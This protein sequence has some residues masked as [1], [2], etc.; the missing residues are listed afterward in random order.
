M[1]ILSYSLSND[2]PCDKVCKDI[3]KAISKLTK[4]NISLSNRQLV[5]YIQEA[6]DSNESLLPKLE[7]KNS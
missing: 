2:L 7:V 1:M 4:Q 5:I 3:S 6:T